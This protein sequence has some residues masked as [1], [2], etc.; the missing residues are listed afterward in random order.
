MSCTARID[1]IMNEVSTYDVEMRILLIEKILDSIKTAG[2]Q[3]HSAGLSELKGLGA[4]LWK[5][6]DVQKYIDEQREW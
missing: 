2:K 1:N 6:I 3:K 5:Q 4:D